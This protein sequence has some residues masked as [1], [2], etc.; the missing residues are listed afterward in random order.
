VNRES[1]IKGISVLAAVLLVF[2]IVFT[3]Y[4]VFWGSKINST[5]LA[6]DKAVT[7]DSNDALRATLDTLE[8][9]WEAKQT[10]KFYVK[11][12]P[13][14]LGRVIQDFTYTAKGTIE[15]EEDTNLRLTA[16]VIDENPKAIIKYSGKSYVVQVGDY[17]GKIYKVEK[18]EKKQVVLNNAG[19]R[20]V[21][22]NKPLKK[23][24]GTDQSSEYSHYTGY[25]VNN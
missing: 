7:L 10:Y 21:L 1:L 18:I 6:I 9:T 14:F 23:Y 24:E 25:N 20:M 15:S 13:L 19:K 4:K 11:Q 5:E 2:F 22:E 12:D 17:V 8:M 3:F 16:T